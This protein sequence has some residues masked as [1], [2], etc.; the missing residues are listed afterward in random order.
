MK[1]VISKLLLGLFALALSTGCRAAAT[2]LTLKAELEKP[3]LPAAVK[4]TALI[5]ITLLAPETDLP[6]DGRKNRVNL[7]L[8]LDKS[9][10]MSSNKKM[11]E[12]CTAAI[13]ALQMLRGGDIFS[14][15][16]YDSS[17]E[18]IM[19]ATALTPAGEVEL[20]AREA[21][22]LKYFVARANTALDRNKIL[23]AVWGM[24]YRGFSRTLDQHIVQLR[25]KIEPD[26]KNPTHIKTV[27][28]IG[29]RFII[30]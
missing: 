29:Y 17:P 1:T 25:K 2:T 26:P 5:R 24:N 30:N 18:V 16:A 9:G 8:V 19:P 28:G 15:V 21:E 11:R 22:L 6:G 27:Y 20:S 10:S 14:L 3:V 7:A 12:A 13:T 23:A 4:Q